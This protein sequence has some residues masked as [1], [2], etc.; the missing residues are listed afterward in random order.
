MFSLV[1]EQESYMLHI[2]QTSHFACNLA[3]FNFE[4]SV[5]MPRDTFL[6]YVYVIFFKVSVDTIYVTLK[7]KAIII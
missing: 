2:F 3:L 6:D 5:I 4:F 7:S 1:V